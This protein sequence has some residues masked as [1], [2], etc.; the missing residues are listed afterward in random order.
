MIFSYHICG[1]MGTMKKAIFIAIVLL[2]A[3]CACRKDGG[4]KP[5]APSRTNTNTRAAKKVPKNGKTTHVNVAKSI[6]SDS[7]G[8]VTGLVYRSD[9]A[10]YIGRPC[11][12]MTAVLER[13]KKEPKNADLY[14]AVALD[15]SAN[16]LERE[17]NLKKAI[18]CAPD[19][20]Y[21]YLELMVYYG[22]LG[23]FPKAKATAQE[24]TAFLDD[25][26]CA[27][28]V[29]KRCKSWLKGYAVYD[30]SMCNESTVGVMEVLAPYSQE[31]ARAVVKYHVIVKNNSKALKLANE[32]M[33][34]E[35]EGEKL[36]W[37][38]I[39]DCVDSPEAQAL[40]NELNYEGERDDLSKARSGL[41]KLQSGYPYSNGEWF[42]SELQ[43]IRRRILLNSTNVD[44]RLEIA[45]EYASVVLMS[46]DRSQLD[47]YIATINPPDSDGKRAEMNV[48]LNSMSNYDMDEEASHYANMLYVS[49][50]ASQQPAIMASILGSGLSVDP[51]MI[52]EAV[53]LYPND[54]KLITAAGNYYKNKNDFEKAAAFH[55]K[56]LG[57]VK[58]DR[59]KSDAVRLLAGDL[60]A[61]GNK[62]ELL[63][64]YSDCEEKSKLNTAEDKVTLFTIQMGVSGTNSVW[65]EAAEL[66]LEEADPNNKA[67]LLDFLVKPNWNTLK[68]ARALAP[69]IVAKAISDPV[70]PEMQKVLL[71]LF[72]RLQELECKP[73][74]LS[75]LHY[76]LVN[77]VKPPHF[78]NT[79]E[80]FP[81]IEE[82]RRE[83]AIW[84]TEAKLGPLDLMTFYV[85]S[86]VYQLGFD[87]PA[88]QVYR[89][90]W[91]RTSDLSFRLRSPLF[92]SFYNFAN[93]DKISKE[94][95]AAAQRSLFEAWYKDFRIFCENDIPSNV[96][97]DPGSSIEQA[98]DQEKREIVELIKARL[99][100][101]G[102]NYTLVNLFRK[103]AKDLKMEKECDDL[104]D[105]H[106]TIDHLVKHPDE[107]WLYENICTDTGKDFDVKAVLRAIMDNKTNL[108][109]LAQSGLIYM[110]RSHGMAKEA[111]EI[112]EKL[113]DEPNAPWFIKH[114]ALYNIKNQEKRLE[115]T[116]EV[117]EAMPPGEGKNE[118]YFQI[119]DNCKGDKFK[120]NYKEALEY[121][122]S[123]KK[124]Y[125]WDR[126][127]MEARNAPYEVDMDALFENYEKFLSEGRS[128]DE[129][130]KMMLG[131]RM[132]YYSDTG[133]Y[134]K[135]IKEGEALVEKDPGKGGQLANLYLQKGQSAKAEETY[136]NLLDAYEKACL[137]GDT[138]HKDWVSTAINGLKSMCQEG[139]AE[140]DE[141]TLR[142]A[143]LQGDNVTLSDYREFIDAGDG[144]L[145]LET[146]NETFEKAL[147][148]AVGDNDKDDLLSNWMGRARDYGDTNTYK[149]VLAMSAEKNLYSMAEYIQF[150]SKTGDDK[151]AFEKGIEA[152]E[153]NK[154]CEVWK[155]RQLETPLFELCVKMGNNDKAWEILS[156][157]WTTDKKDPY[158][159]L[160]PVGIV[161]MAEKLG[162]GKE[163]IEGMEKFLSETGNAYSKLSNA[164]GIFNAYRN[165]KDEEGAKA[166]VDRF[167][168][169]APK[170]S[171]NPAQ[172]LEL[173]FNSSNPEKGLELV[174]EA[175]EDK[176]D[177]NLDY[178]LTKANM[179]FDKNNDRDGKI[180][181]LKSLPDSYEQR[182]QL[183]SVYQNSGDERDREQAVSLLKENMRDEDVDSYK[184]NNARDQLLQIALKGEKDQ[185]LINEIINDYT[186]DTTLSKT[187][188]NR[189][190][191]D[192]YT[193]SEDYVKADNI[194][195]QWISETKNPYEKIETRRNY[196]DMLEKSGRT[197]DAIDQ[198]KELMDS[199]KNDAYGRDQTRDKLINLYQKEGDMLKA[200]NIRRERITEYEKI[201]STVPYGSRARELKQ[202][203]EAEKKAI[204][205]ARNAKG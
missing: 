154:D 199:Q 119:L 131:T 190:L 46:T 197:R 165:L 11:F 92:Y 44:E 112:G 35:S 95:K 77:G 111:D 60:A 81:N 189:A 71:T 113:L 27:S 192:I 167:L 196:A 163:A 84:L 45:G 21:P 191:A 103:L 99:K 118:L 74:M 187:E 127:L 59:E 83:I 169:T 184:R 160:D 70:S 10:K 130:E 161:R 170:T 26:E 174:K 109:N 176:S 122:Q 22:S 132:E 126:L 185:Y 87:E 6:S 36:A 56:L 104:L 98:T 5:V 155:K 181:F 39:L 76:F 89:T 164:M 101:V 202:K 139:Q 121:L 38:E 100:N 138:T 2:C 13:L 16:S 18:E 40:I 50:P 31:I 88:L 166:F 168:E 48:V 194:Y 86:I 125:V 116:I 108:T 150:L 24:L 97:D 135:A 52:D 96:S 128:K 90:M 175:M 20:P 17:A 67:I 120:E 140:L 65:Q 145:S 147:E 102:T 136:R 137:E 157:K 171:G 19:A 4:E 12:E 78:Y 114:S 68:N 177:Y 106:F 173:I 79:V 200:E 203:I 204:E 201:L 28:R 172:R 182:S 34:P 72:E 7:L 134:S 53:K 61:V 123:S 153:K 51:D 37:I 69:E 54:I 57:L 159:Y 129:V 198:Y 8:S 42:G 133:D 179:Y 55:K 25:K 115:K 75:L 117:V 124:D 107:I 66:F 64:L 32:F 58:T 148:L 94:S 146:M 188:L 49:A 47:E 152:W 41:I 156:D 141:Y 29:V 205:D 183:A 91:D 80:L 63:N 3:L 43:D 144:I 193:R 73:E 162:K 1:R 151:E 23:D 158:M 110:M 143:F 142:R 14:F 186:S 33:K 30:D 15:L 82:A 9:Y 195:N 62:E 180:D 105:S 178:F 85:N 149:K 93:S